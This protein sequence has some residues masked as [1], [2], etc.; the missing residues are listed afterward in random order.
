MAKHCD[1]SM[2]TLAVKARRTANNFGGLMEE[3]GLRDRR[4]REVRVE[5]E[6]EIEVRREKQI[7]K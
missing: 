1:G 7:I 4:E 3:A 2:V 5:A 6:G